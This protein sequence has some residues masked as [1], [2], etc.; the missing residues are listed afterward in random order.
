MTDP[1]CGLAGTATTVTRVEPAVAAVLAV[2]LTVALTNAARPPD[3]A[4]SG[5][6]APSC[7]CLTGG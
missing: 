2:V 6:R 5:G 3:D 1:W 7:A 4:T